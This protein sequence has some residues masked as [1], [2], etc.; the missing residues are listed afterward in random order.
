MPHLAYHEREELS[1]NDKDRK[2]DQA[3]T[4]QIL[5]LSIQNQTLHL[6]Y[7]RSHCFVSSCLADCGSGLLIAVIDTEESDAGCQKP[8]KKKGEDV[9]CW[10]APVGRG[11]NK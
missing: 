3:E 8:Q 10:S 6:L 4:K 2:T 7:F 1:S 9:C 5:L 11:K